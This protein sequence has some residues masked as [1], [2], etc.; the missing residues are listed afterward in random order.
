MAEIIP[1]AD[2]QHQ[3]ATDS[4]RPYPVIRKSKLAGCNIRKADYQLPLT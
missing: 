2:G 1:K 3:H 4:H